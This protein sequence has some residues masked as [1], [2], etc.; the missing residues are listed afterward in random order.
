MERD[1]IRRLIGFACSPIDSF[2]RDTGASRL[3]SMRGRRREMEDHEREKARGRGRDWERRYATELLR[4]L[5]RRLRRDEGGVY[6]NAANTMRWCP[7]FTRT[8]SA[9]EPHL[10]KSDML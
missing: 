2:L 5:E 8:T 7:I 1:E 10:A 4:R 3:L 9:H 6:P